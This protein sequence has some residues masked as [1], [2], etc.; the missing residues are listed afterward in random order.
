MA[1]L[2]SGLTLGLMSMDSVELEVLKKTGT[3]EEK[4]FAA[5]IMPVRPSTVDP[6]FLIPRHGHGTGSVLSCSPWSGIPAG[7]W[8]HIQG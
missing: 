7:G 6:S 1:G 2:M 3:A 5:I 4:R 8:I